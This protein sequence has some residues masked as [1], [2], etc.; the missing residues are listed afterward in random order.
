M[1]SKC[2]GCTFS[3]FEYPPSVCKRCKGNV[4]AAFGRIMHEAGLSYDQ[5]Q[6]E[7]ESAL[8][9]ARLAPCKEDHYA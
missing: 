1:A 7:R 3:S 4:K 5:I 6:R 9:Q 2:K 8:Q